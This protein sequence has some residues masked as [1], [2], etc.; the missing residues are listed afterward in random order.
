MIFVAN[1]EIPPN[2]LKAVPI[3]TRLPVTDGIVKRVWV[4][5]RWGS[6]NLCGCR[7]F[8]HEFQIWPLSLGE[9]FLSRP[10]GIQFEESLSVDAAPREFYIE[11]YNHDDTF[12]HT[13]EVAVCL[14][15]AEGSTK[16]EELLRFLETGYAYA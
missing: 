10:E 3:R 16:L 2:T 11:A 1:L 9:W 7:I 6:A 15:R 12:A 14:L 5:W 13:V 4:R 8:Y